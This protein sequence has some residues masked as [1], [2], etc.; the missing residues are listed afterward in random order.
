[1]PSA[2]L[3]PNTLGGGTLKPPSRR[4]NDAQQ[5][6]ARLVNDDDGME[7]SQAVYKRI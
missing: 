4:V 7:L 2:G 6:Q 1:M 5:A 3:A